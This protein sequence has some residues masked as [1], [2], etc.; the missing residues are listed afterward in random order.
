MIFTFVELKIFQHR[1]A[2]L[3]GQFL[4]RHM[5]YQ[6]SLAKENFLKKSM[7]MFVA[8]LMLVRTVNFISLYVFAKKLESLQDTGEMS[9]II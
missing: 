5:N 6:F 8:L 4:S 2:H 1:I 7:H 9:F 3:G